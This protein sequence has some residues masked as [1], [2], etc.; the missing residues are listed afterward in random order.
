MHLPHSLTCSPVKTVLTCDSARRSSMLKPSCLLASG[1]DALFP[2]SP[3]RSRRTQVGAEWPVPD[4]ERT[5]LVP[6]GPL[7]VRDRQ[8]AG[9][10]LQKPARVHRAGLVTQTSRRS[11]SCTPL[12]RI[13]VWCRIPSY[14]T[15]QVKL[16]RRS[17]SNG[18]PRIRT[19]R[20]IR[21][22]L[23]INSKNSQAAPTSHW[24]V[25]SRA[26]QGHHK[27]TTWTAPARPRMQVA[28]TA[29]PHRIRRGRFQGK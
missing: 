10:S 13:C 21:A 16:R 25:R 29:N 15:T 9:Q 24:F 3:S 28:R 20:D 19:A 14:I 27:G 7:I 1:A 17:F 11:L 23:R 6:G 8:S 2:G 4:A 22:W 18:R 26:S 5:V 12:F